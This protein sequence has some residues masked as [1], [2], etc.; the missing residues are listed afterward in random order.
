M[1]RL[2]KMSDHLKAAPAASGAPKK[3]P[4]TTHILDTTRGR[5]AANVPVKLFS[6][7]KDSS[8]AL[9]GEGVTNE[10]GR[11]LGLLSAELVP[12]TYRLEFD[13]DV[14]FR[15]L[16][17]EAF[18]PYVQICFRVAAGEA[19]YHVPL[20]LNPYSYSTYRGS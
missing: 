6:V 15:R 16:G 20:L 14:Y 9:L 19:H 10:D 8:C 13:T 5:P 11:C 7:G 3:S 4:I 12:G 1:H 2:A 18:F 17:I